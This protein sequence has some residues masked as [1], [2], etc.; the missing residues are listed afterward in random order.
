MTAPC[1]WLIGVLGLMIWR[2]TSPA[3]HTLL[4]FTRFV[5]VDASPRATSAK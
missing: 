3:T 4:T 1:T 2:P 5:C